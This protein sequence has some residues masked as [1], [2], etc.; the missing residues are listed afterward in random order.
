VDDGLPEHGAVH[1]VAAAAQVQA[2][3]CGEVRQSSGRQ[4]LTAIV[5]H[6]RVVT[7][8]QQLEA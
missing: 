8:V 2:P 6:S 5:R 1:M 4:R 3:A 7:Q